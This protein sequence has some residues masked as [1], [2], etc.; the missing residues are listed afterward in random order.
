MRCIWYLEQNRAKEGDVMR[1][2]YSTLNRT[3]LRRVM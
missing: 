3:G 2:A 1:G